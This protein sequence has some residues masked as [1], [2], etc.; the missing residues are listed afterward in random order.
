MLNARTA[1]ILLTAFMLCISSLSTLSYSSLG[2]TVEIY[3]YMVRIETSSDWTTVSFYNGPT[4]IGYDFNL[5]RGLEAPELRYRVSTEYISISKRAYDTTPVSV[6]IRILALRGDESCHVL[7]RKGNIGCTNVSMYIWRAGD[8]ELEWCVV[9]EG[10]N[11][12]YPGTNDRVFNVN[13]D[14]LYKYPVGNATYE[15]VAEGFRDCVLAFYYPWYGTAHG[16]SDRWFHWEDVAEDAIGNVAHYPLLGVYDSQDERLIEAHMLMADY[17]GI[18]GFIV[19]WWGPDSFEDQSLKRIVKLAESR[20]FKITIYYESY[21]P[22]R[23]L[24]SVTEIVRELSYVVREYAES[25]AFLKIDGRPALFIYNVKAHN[26]SPEF[27]LK[28]RKKLE[29]EVGSVILI[30]DLRDCSYLS[31]FDGFHT[32]IEL[33]SNVM[34]NLYGFYVDKME[35]GLAGLSFDEAVDKIQ[36]GE[37][38]KIQRK[39]LFYT[40]VPGFD[41]RKIGEPGLYVGRLEG[42][43]YRRH[44]DDALGVGARSILITSWNELHEG[45]EIEPTVEF[46][47]KF[48]NITR[49][50]VFKLKQRTAGK[51]PSPSLDIDNIS[52]SRRGDECYIKL[53]NRGEG[54]AIAVKVYALLP[55]GVEGSFSDAYRQPSRPCAAIAT[56]P[57]LKKGEAYDLILKIENSSG[58]PFILPELRVSYYS[59]AGSPRDIELKNHLVAYYVGFVSGY[60]M[61]TVRGYGIW[62]WCYGYG[63]R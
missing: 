5:T 53:V 62:L 17:A 24:T 34:R 28:V 31:V 48:L 11:P 10:V 40:V 30:G 25:P 44:W 45:T 37:R 9:S 12:Q 50:Y 27:W 16:A 51:P 59:I 21:R 39:A 1:S 57:L 41:N 35:V 61:A 2:D 22:W 43:T 60:G 7:I 33:N 8:Y 6:D 52:L 56:I 29:E 36:V 58:D 15:D 3:L 19:S 47:F 23:P 13:F 55:P 46:G 20:D 42:D 4:V 63:I 18:D 49:S 32:Y 54:D 38:V 14:Q 26:R